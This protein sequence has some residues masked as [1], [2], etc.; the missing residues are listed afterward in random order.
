KHLYLVCAIALIPGAAFAQS[1]VERLE[2]LSED[3]SRVMAVMM[4]N[5]VEAQGGDGAALRS[6]ASAM[7]PWDDRMRAAGACMLDGYESASSRAEVDSMLSNMESAIN[8]MPSMTMTEFTESDMS[9]G[10]MPQ[11]M[12]LEQTAAINEQCGVMEL[13]MEAMQQS[14]FMEAMMTAGSTVPDS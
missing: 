3:M 9:D 14:G 2:S 13:Q 6:A 1:Q 7:P 10:M 5:E 8:Q 11:G 12:T 4:A